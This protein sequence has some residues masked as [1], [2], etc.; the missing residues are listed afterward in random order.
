MQIL[1]PR[2]KMREACKH[3]TSTLLVQGWET[4]S[5]AASLHSRSLVEINTPKLTKFNKIRANQLI[6][7]QCLT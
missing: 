4:K 6:Q 5:Y 7:I 3:P 1:E 2:R